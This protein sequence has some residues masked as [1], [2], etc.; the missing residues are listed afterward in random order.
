MINIGELDMNDIFFHLSDF[1]IKDK[2]S[3]VVKF[4]NKIC[5]YVKNISINY[6]NIFIIVSGDIA[7]SGKT[8][9]YM[10]SIELF[11]S[12]KEAL[13]GK[14]IYFLIVPG[15][16]DC[17]FLGRINIRENL[18]KTLKDRDDNICEEE[19]DIFKDVQNEYLKFYDLYAP[20]EKEKVADTPYCKIYSI[21]GMYTYNFFLFNSALFCK[22][23]D[24]YGD[25]HFPL[26]ELSSLKKFVSKE[27]ASINIAV[28]HHPFNWQDDASYIEVK[29]F[30]E[31]NFSMIFLGHEHNGE[32]R[33]VQKNCQTRFLELNGGIL[34]NNN[35]L[36]D[37]FTYKIDTDVINATQYVWDDTREIFCE[38]QIGT[39]SFDKAGLQ[40]KDDFYKTLVSTKILSNS[41]FEIR[42]DKI[43][44]SPLLIKIGKNKDNGKTKKITADDV[45]SSE[46]IYA[47]IKSGEKYGKTSFLKMFFLNEYNKGNVPVYVNGDELSTNA[48]NN[49][50]KFLEKKFKEE[51]DSVNE[52]DYETFDRSKKSIFIDDID[53]SA[54]LKDIYSFLS[55]LKKFSDKVIVSMENTVSDIAAGFSKE[56]ITFK[57]DYECLEI[58]EFNNEKKHQLYSKWCMLNKE[59]MNSKN[60]T[61]F[62]KNTEQLLKKGMVPS[63]PFYLLSMLCTF[64]AGSISALTAESGCA[65]FYR[66]II[67][68]MLQNAAPNR[69]KA[70]QYFSYIQYIAYYMLENHKKVVSVKEFCDVTKKYC[71][72]R[73]IDA[74]LQQI[75]LINSGLMVKKDD[76]LSFSQEYIFYFFAS[77]YISINLDKEDVS[78]IVDNLFD[79][80]YEKD[81]ANIIVFLSYHSGH[82]F[83]LSKIEKKAKEIFDKTKIEST[84]D[85]WNSTKFVDALIKELPKISVPEKKGVELQ[86]D[87]ARMLDTYEE[88]KIIN[89][90]QELAED[91]DKVILEA[92]KLTE[93][94]G[95][96]LKNHVADIENDDKISLMKYVLLVHKNIIQSYMETIVQKSGDFLEVI[97]DKMNEKKLN[98]NDTDVVYEFGNKLIFYVTCLMYMSCISHIKNSIINKDLWKV[99]EK[100]SDDTDIKS[101]FFDLLKFSSEVEIDDTFPMSS[102]RTFISEY[103]EAKTVFSLIF[104]YLMVKYASTYYDVIKRETF[105]SILSQLNIKNEIKKNIL[106][107]SRKH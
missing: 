47:Y 65:E 57:D 99:V 9:E 69:Y 2:N 18:L 41:P 106:I 40:L 4:K 63:T 103:K 38:N 96:I 97:R 68:T 14:N 101:K 49:I 30:F 33:A 62:L 84:L 46:N 95:A 29:N 88:K 92:L 5:Q 81:S 10:D 58:V 94:I 66:S 51:Y 71:D 78:L 21:K 39:L 48:R 16:H 83:V 8:D 17:N 82:K 50:Q 107:E 44:V 54:K 85:V 15:N 3:S 35:K 100:I 11:E 24:Q 74:P 93:I 72:S 45:F 20:D 73:T 27:T 87:N 98:I 104:T 13:T 37:F 43:Y 55:E 64:K 79:S 42:L 32:V 105:D 86:E 91:F 36:G 67:T 34:G 31:K 23:D 26:K 52:F 70:S 53:S 59:D 76:E 1:H 19:F 80:I 25:I 90:K 22:K 75:D 7:F 60:V 6:D 28:S 56:V 12:I 89:T 102:F 61:I 77:G